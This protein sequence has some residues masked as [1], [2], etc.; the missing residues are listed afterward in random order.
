MTAVEVVHSLVSAMSYNIINHK[1]KNV[2][3]VIIPV[4]AY[5]HD[6]IRNEECSAYYIIANASGAFT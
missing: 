3:S 5:A 1:Y 2:H 4:F 6:F